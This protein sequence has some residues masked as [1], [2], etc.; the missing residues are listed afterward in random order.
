MSATSQSRGEAADNS[1]LEMLKFSRM[2][3]L[4]QNLGLK[5]VVPLSVGASVIID[6]VITFALKLIGLPVFYSITVGM[7]IAIAAPVSYFA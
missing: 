3:S 7:T 4:V 5:G 2:E 6:M 1:D